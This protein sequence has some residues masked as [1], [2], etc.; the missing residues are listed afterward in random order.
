MN[1]LV[2]LASFNGVKYI[3]EQINS[4]LT[5]EYVNVTLFIFDDGSNDGSFEL[6]LSKFEYV[7]AEQLFK[8]ISVTAI[9][10]FLFVNLFIIIFIFK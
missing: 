5:Q 3:E 6:L 1:I 7:F 2:I 8:K 10:I 4:I 9:K